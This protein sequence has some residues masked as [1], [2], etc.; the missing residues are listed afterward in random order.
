MGSRC[1]VCN[2]NHR[3]VGRGGYLANIRRRVGDMVMRTGSSDVPSRGHRGWI[4]P[5]AR[6][7][8]TRKARL[9]RVFMEAEFLEP[10][11]LL[12]TIP[13]A[14][15]VGALQTIGVGTSDVANVSSPVI[16]IDPVNPLKM[17]AVWVDN[18]PKLPAPGPFV[19]VQGAYTTN[20]GQSWLSYSLNS[21]M[22]DPNTTNPTIP[23]TQ[24]TDP[25]I[26][27]DRND[28]FYVSASFHNAGGNS[29]SIVLEKF[30]F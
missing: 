12:A 20:G 13:A 21:V 18:D 15:A 10:R 14:T 28:N 17:A 27:F 2:R 1:R 3:F 19:I 23:Y 4:R 29:G 25:S 24:V 26:G 5:D 22:L 6:L 11:T 30:A 16:S 9:R 7:S 8:K